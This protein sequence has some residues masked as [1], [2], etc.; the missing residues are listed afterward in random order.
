MCLSGDVRVT[1]GVN[2]DACSR[3]PST[4]AKISRINEGGS[5]WGE[6]SDERVAGKAATG[7][8]ASA[9]SCLISS[10]CNREVRRVGYTRNVRVS[11]GVHADGHAD[12]IVKSS[13]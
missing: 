8:S 11:G 2:R 3:V 5:A 9:E 12:V 10:R 1:G 7:E 6:L 4:S 13:T